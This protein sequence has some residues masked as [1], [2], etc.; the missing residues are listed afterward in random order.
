MV[1]ISAAIMAVIPPHTEAAEG[2][3]SIPTDALNQLIRTNGQLGV[4]IGAGSPD[5]DDSN[6]IDGISGSSMAKKMENDLNIISNIPEM[7]TRNNEAYVSENLINEDSNWNRLNRMDNAKIENYDNS[8]SVDSASMRDIYSNLKYLYERDRKSNHIPIEISNSPISSTSNINRYLELLSEMDV[9]QIYIS[10]KV[11]SLNFNENQRICS[12][13]KYIYEKKSAKNHT[14]NFV[15]LA[16]SYLQLES[17]SKYDYLFQDEAVEE[18]TKEENRIAS[19]DNKIDIQFKMNYLYDRIIT[20]DPILENDNVPAMERALA[21]KANLNYLNESKNEE[22]AVLKIDQNAKVMAN[23]NIRSNLEYLYKTTNDTKHI[24]SANATNEMQ[25]NRP[26]NSSI[27]EIFAGIRNPILQNAIQYYESIECIPIKKEKN[28]G[29]KK[30]YAIVIGIDE[31]KDRRSLHNSVNDADT[32]ASLLEMYGYSI[33]K[34]TDNTSYKPTKHNIL[35]VALGEVK[36]K[37][38]RGNVIIFF[39]GHGNI[40]HDN[41]YYLIPQDANGAKSTYISKSEFSDHI[42]DIKNLAIIIDACNSGALSDITTDGQMI[43]TSSNTNEASNEEWMGSLS[44]FTN[45]LCNAIRRE[46][47]IGNGVLLQS[48]FY[49][50]FNDTVKWSNYHLLSQTPILTDMTQNKRFYLN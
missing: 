50:A 23:S 24:S 26:S 39:S 34:L 38:D 31:Y 8:L 25:V 40:D 11:E 4:E 2:I 48:C 20:V 19:T 6:N 43:L 18:I 44:V 47:R 37:K 10:E 7:K 32:F 9:S 33:I 36:Q 41:E 15:G 27:Y 29:Y 35:D 12:G 16:D 42:K 17:N 21:I 22:L 28:A 49:D 13:H 3:S 46:G 1:L 5:Y 14:P 30:N 45:N